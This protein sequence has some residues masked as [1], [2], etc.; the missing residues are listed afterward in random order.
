MQW[1][2][3]QNITTSL[4]SHCETRWYSLMKVCVSVET[5][6]E[7][8]LKCITWDDDQNVDISKLRPDVRDIIDMQHFLDNQMLIKLAQPIVDEIGILERKKS[9]LADVWISLTRAYRNIRDAKIRPETF[10]TLQ[11]GILQ[12]LGTMGCKDFGE[13][14]YII[15]FFLHPRYAKVAISKK[16]KADDIGKMIYKLCCVY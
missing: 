4:Q 10:K 13:D 12:I 11:K 1:A 16:H 14:I 7:G 8:F 6:R 15:A 5:F 9:T 3:E 2:K